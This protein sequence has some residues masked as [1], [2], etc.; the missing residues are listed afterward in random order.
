MHKFSPER[1]ARLE[2]PERYRLI[3]PGPTLRRFGLRPGMRLLDV[4]AGT[5]F[6]SRAAAEIVGPAGKVYSADMSQAM[7]TLL[8]ERAAAPMIETVL[9]QEYRI[10]IPDASADMALLAFVLH[11]NV[12]RP[13]LLGEVMRAVKPDGKVLIVEWK[14]QDEEMGPPMEE[15][16]GQADLARELGPFVVVEEGSL[17]ES[18]YYF[19]IARREG[20]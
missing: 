7:L 10:P 4:G 3:P 9:S 2:M 18:H 19:L 16:L 20:G 11:E 5:G 17:N 1:W 15:R 6:F 8:R 13:R 14:K 12:D